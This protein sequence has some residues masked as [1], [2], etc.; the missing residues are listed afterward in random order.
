MPTAVQ[1]L[2]I[3]TLLTCV[4]P[5]GADVI[6]LSEPVA[7]DPFSETFG[8]VLDLNLPH[9]TL[10]EA[11]ASVTGGDNLGKDM[12]IEARVGQVCQKKGCFFVAMEGELAIRVSFQD[13]SF[14]IPTDSGDKTVTI[15]GRLVEKELTSDQVAHFKADAGDTELPI[16]AGKIY[17]IVASAVRI[18]I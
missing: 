11:V 1:K 9:V 4:L 18:P 8:E 15:S 7:V 13:Y 12:L 6:R 2:L 16:R 17:E 5:A 10:A 14:F 3:T